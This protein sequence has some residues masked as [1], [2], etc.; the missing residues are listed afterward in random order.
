MKRAG[1]G[2]DDIISKLTSELEQAKAALQVE[3]NQREQAMVFNRTISS[4]N[5]LIQS[6]LD[7]DEIM[8]LIVS[9]A[10]T[11]LGSETVAISLRKGK[12]W[13]VN[14]VYGFPKNVVGTRMNDE[15]EPHAVLA[16]NTGKPVAIDDAFND[17]RVNRQHM[18]KWGV[19]SVLVVPIM[20]KHDA[21]G[22]IFFNFHKTPFSFQEVHL[23]FASNLASSAS[24]VLSNAR[25]VGDLHKELTARKQAEETL[26]RSL[27][28]LA[29]ISDTASQLLMSQTPQL[30]V[31]TLCQR[32][33]EYLDCHAF[34]NFLVD[35]EKNCLRLNAYS[36]IS[37]KD[38]KKIHFLDYGVGIC[39]C[40]ARDACR[41]VAE[42]IPIA[43]DI[44]TDFVRSFG[45]KAY[46]CHP[47]FSDGRVIGTL[48]FGTRSHL[49]FT[50]DELSLMKTVT[51]LVATAME[52]M[53]LLLSAE[54]RADELELRVQERTA[55]LRRQAELLDLAHD[56]IILRDID[57][58]ISFW[59]SGAEQTYGWKK[60]EAIGRKAHNL[61][62]T[63][64]PINLEEIA[65]I[66]YKVGRWEGELVH[67]GRDHKAI[68]V[69][70]RWAFRQDTTGGPSQIM[71]VNRDIT[72]RKS[73]EDA[74]RLANAYNRSL[75]EAS[76]DPLVTINP[77]G[78]ITDANFA[79]EKA[80]GYSRKELIG[81]D[82]SD[83]FTEPEK[84]EAGYQQVFSKGLVQD[85]PLEILHRDGHNTPVLYNAAVYRDNTGKITG[86]FAAARDITERKRAE[87]QLIKAKEE[88]ERTF[89]AI[90]DPIMIVD[91]NHRVAKVN[92]A[93]AD[94]LKVSPASA[95]GL[96][97]FK[98]VHDGDE[99]PPFCPHSRLLCDGKPNLAEIYEKKL[100][101][102]FLV[103]VSPL[104]GHDGKLFGS[105]HYARDIT[106][107][108]RAEESLRMMSAYNRSLIEASLDP[109]V[110]IDSEG[111]ISDVN[112]ATEQATGYSRD[113]LIGTDFSDYF[114]NPEKAKT[115]YQLVFKE[116]T[117]RDYDLEIRHRDGHVTPVLYNASIYRDETGRAMGVFAAARDI[118]E[119][120]RLEKEFRQVQKMQAIGTLASGIA[121]DFNNIIAGI[122]GFT[123]M[124]IDDV[125]QEDRIHRRLELVLK[126]AHRGRDLVRQ[127][128]TFSRKSEQ[129]KKPVSMSYILN[130]ALPLMR[131]SLPSTIEVRK[132]VLTE[133]DIIPA[134]QT[135][136]HQVMFNLCA[137]AAHAMR[138]KG[139]VLEFTLAEDNI[140]SHEPDVSG[141]FKPGAYVKLTISD[142][143]CG[144]KPE[145]LERIF[146]PFFTT[147]AP[148]EGTGLGLSVVHGIIKS[149]DGFIRV[150]SNPGEGTSFTIYIPKI[151]QEAVPQANGGTD[152]GGGTESVLIVDDEVL[153]VEM[154]KQRL[155]RLGYKATGAS[156]GAEALR[157]FGRE[158]NSFDLVITD[159]TMPHMTGL[160]LAKELLRIKPDIP[161]IMCSGLNEPV[162]LERAKKTGVKEFFVKPVDKIEF[163]QLIRRVL[164]KETSEGGQ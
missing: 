162:P 109:L 44:R 115:G 13:I 79:T 4:I 9:E 114:T 110:T 49:T 99:P 12:D 164:D 84:A 81:T 125:P 97:C 121:H 21:I 95:K 10:A 156:N 8:K 132:H 37:G 93:M 128:L 65:D 116:K 52:H 129:E 134:D 3:I 151:G 73:A 161:V 153:L 36:G 38:A 41:I 133:N 67:T 66:A 94:K 1:R 74:L 23:N 118:T 143:G 35:D 152:I 22:V 26:K 63:V 139:G 62:Q 146:D 6:T 160:E 80:T 54:A 140:G 142:T 50:E 46:A 112:T 33:M 19:R 103:S 83:Y 18:I 138:D 11:A 34:F 117:V 137:N 157:L 155:E 88:W 163:A 87:S 27:E 86:V 5:G 42:N 120:V 55:D 7:S 108:K 71:E 89:D 20:S 61:L 29:I 56:A 78:K 148:G 154:N 130:E 32:V 106:E 127:I 28:R 119:N 150:S 70:S 72:E 122:I 60:D 31:E 107:R 92:K 101:G 96:K 124:A 30:I 126:G 64:F 135:Q 47:L 147:K 131:A 123:E 51:D 111:R 82:F 58:T 76:L 16:I 17:E 2:R 57:G 85:Y 90:T 24:L 53:R 69:H 43:P 149:H 144:I 104:Y 77:D 136:M 75:I 98:A 91:T 40:A 102:Y 48:S 141:G 59:S 105:V 100:G 14:Y 68:V 145:F 39:G 159:Y 45:I 158:P 15:E 25:L 113:K